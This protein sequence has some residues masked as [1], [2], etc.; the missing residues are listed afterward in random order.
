[1]FDAEVDAAETTATVVVAEAE[2]PFASVTVTVYGPAFTAAE[3]GML[4][5][6]NVEVKLFGPVQL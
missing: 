1:M 2:Q 5:F 6:C 3:L 4:G